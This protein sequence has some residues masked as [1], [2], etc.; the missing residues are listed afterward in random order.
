[1]FL[2]VVVVV[3]DADAHLTQDLTV[4]VAT[5]QPL[6]ADYEIVVVDNASRDD[7]V[8]RL[9]ALTQEDGLP[10]LQV[11]AL[12][13]PVDADTAVWVGLDNAIGDF[14]AVYDPAH[15]AADALAAMLE[16]ARA[17]AEVVFAI[18]DARPTDGALYRL[19]GGAFALLYALF[20]GVRF[21]SDAPGFRLV[22]RS[23]VNLVLTHPTPAFTWRHLAQLAGFSHAHVRTRSAP[24][25]AS[26]RSLGGSID[27]GLRLLVSTTRA[28]LRSVTW[29]STVAASLNVLYSGYVI[30]VYI[31]KDDVAPG[32]TT[33]SLQTSGMF[34]LLSL[35]LLVLG[36]YVLQLTSALRT[37]PTWHVAREFTS[38]S[39]LR[40]R[41]LNVVDAPDEV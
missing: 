27:R 20:H 9:R 37:G 19:F 30:A 17:G 35:I 40:R 4:L 29:L 34:F 7:T 5:L 12:T 23:V 31:L 3:R 2:S 25:R 15:D 33:L 11:L 38:A 16:H 28:P 8:G 22:S 14:V 36:E 10:N 32:W 26:S 39:I 18:N 6:V 41:Q 13:S 1:M 21:V 24:R